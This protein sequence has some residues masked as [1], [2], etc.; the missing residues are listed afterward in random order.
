MQ[1]QTPEEG[2]IIKIPR[3]IRT[4]YADGKQLH[5]TDK[6]V[7][8]NSTFSIGPPETMFYDHREQLAVE[9]LGETDFKKHFIIVA[10]IGNLNSKT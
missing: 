9:I 5:R 10:E 6:W 4:F 3:D 1:N 7:S 2:Q 8:K